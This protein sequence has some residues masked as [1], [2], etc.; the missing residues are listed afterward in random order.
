MNAKVSIIVPTYN[1]ANLI[2]ETLNSIIAQTHGNWECLLID[3][4]ST[5]NTREVID[6][7][8]KKDSRFKLFSRP[9]NALKGPS[10]CR[11]YGID[12][13]VGDFL[14]FFDDDDI[15]HPQNLELCVLELL[16]KNISFCRYIRNVFYGNFDYNFDFSKAY[17]SFYIDSKDIERMLK[18]ELFCITSSIMWKKECF[19]NHRF[20][21]HLRYAEEW[22][23]YSRIVSSGFRGISIDKCLFYGRKHMEQIT[24]VFYGDDFVSKSSY[25]EAIL[26]VIKNLKEKELL[27]DSLL[28]YFIQMSLSFREFNLFENILKILNLSNVK[29][30]KWKLFYIFFPVRLKLYRYWKMIKK[31]V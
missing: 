28:R 21:E 7:F 27:S 16:K 10:A 23:L 29:K 15:A 20:E 19:L 12:E 5:D 22:E 1:R 13:S 30:I 18:N 2:G 9:E 4:G 17:T 24:S 31:I 14:I 25:N 3:D 8:L 11:N 26:L 6:E